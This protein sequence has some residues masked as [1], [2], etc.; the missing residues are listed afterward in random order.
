MYIQHG[1]RIWQ[2]QRGI[3]FLPRM[4]TEVKATSFG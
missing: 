3:G 1:L 2:S 4:L